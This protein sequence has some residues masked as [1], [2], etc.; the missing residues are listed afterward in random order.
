M[1]T[2]VFLVHY[3]RGGS[4]IAM[5]PYVRALSGTRCL[6]VTRRND[7]GMDL[8]RG[9]V[10]RIMECRFPLTMNITAMDA[11]LTG[12]GRFV[13]WCKDAVK[14]PIA[15][16]IALRMLR[17]ERPSLVVIGDFPLLP[18]AAACRILRIPFIVL[19]QTTVSTRP[20][21]RF[22]VRTILRTADRVVGITGLHLDFLGANEDRLGTVI[23]NTFQQNVSSDSTA[24]I[25]MERLQI[26]GKKVVLFLGGVSRIKGT[27]R[28]AAAVSAVCRKRQDVVFILAGPFHHRYSSPFGAGTSDIDP[29]V[30]QRVFSE[31]EQPHCRDSVRIIGETPFVDHLFRASCFHMVLNEYPHFSRP[32]IEGW[33]LRTPVIATRDRFTEYQVNSGE[34]GVLVQGTDMAELVRVMESLLD[35]EQECRRLG[36]NGEHV[37]RTEYAPDTVQ[38]KI[39]SLLSPFIGKA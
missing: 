37:F 19:V 13:K 12:R 21:K 9:M 27:E 4:T 16:L 7:E 5:Q 17:R 15:L 25:F 36:D 33:A 3:G 14:G 26:Q 23:H 18:V 38:Q 2:M 6:L 24:K 1:T 22:L 11:F 20:V 35:D 30:N 29:E 28:F 32:I 34:N 39:D 8:F 10:E 31:L